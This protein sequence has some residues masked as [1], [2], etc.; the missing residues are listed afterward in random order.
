MQSPFGKI[1]FLIHKLEGNKLNY[2]ENDA[3]TSSSSLE[4][5]YQLFFLYY[6]F[7]LLRNLIQNEQHNDSMKVGVSISAIL[8]VLGQYLVFTCLMEQLQKLV[9]KIILLKIIVARNAYTN[10]QSLACFIHFAHAQMDL[11]SKSQLSCLTDFL[12][13]PIP[14]NFGK[15]FVSI[16]IIILHKALTTMMISIMN[17]AITVIDSSFFS[18]KKSR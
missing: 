2:P 1:N 16:T 15:V 9:L 3:E 18:Y 13:Q 10:T 5:L 8:T 14:G 11:E 7:I 17:L 4:F 12:G 6:A